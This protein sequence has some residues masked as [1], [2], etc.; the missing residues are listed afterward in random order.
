MGNRQLLSVFFIVVILIAVFFTMGYVVGTHIPRWS[1]PIARRQEKPLVVDPPRPNPAGHRFN[2]ATPLRSN[3]MVP[4]PVD[5]TTTPEVPPVRS[6]PKPSARAALPRRTRRSQSRAPAR[7]AGNSAATAPV[8]ASR[9]PASPIYRSLPWQGRSRVLCVDA[10]EEGLPRLFTPVAEKRA[11][12][13]SGGA[14]QDAASHRASTTDSAEGRVLR[15]STPRA[16]IAGL[17]CPTFRRPTPARPP[18]GVGAQRRT[19]FESLQAA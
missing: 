3:S 18:A 6:G 10:R 5:P 11:C 2:Q 1:R 19:H 16:E 8:P 14:V 15:A 13:R 9:T 7:Q 12:T 17:P 4:A